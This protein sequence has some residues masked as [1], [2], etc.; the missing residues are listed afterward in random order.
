MGQLVFE[1][2]S[3]N[4]FSK[5]S[6]D[7]FD[8]KDWEYIKFRLENTKNNFLKFRYASLICNKDPHKDIAK[9]CIDSSWNLINSY[10]K[11][12]LKIIFILLILLILY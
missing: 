5:P 8:D 12:F 7:D 9:I 3:N 11:I 6:L 10:E 4:S 1:D 2:N